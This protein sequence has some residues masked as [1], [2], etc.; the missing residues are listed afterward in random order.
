VKYRPSGK[1]IWGPWPK[2]PPGCA[3]GG[4]KTTDTVQWC[5]IAAFNMKTY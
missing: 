3:H 2:F 5:C 4:G 1:H